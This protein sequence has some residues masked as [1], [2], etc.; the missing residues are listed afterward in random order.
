MGYITPCSPL[1]VNRRFGETSPR[2][3]LPPAFT[4]VS[5]SVYST[6]KVQ[7]ICSSEMSANFKLA[8]RRCIPEDSTPHNCRCE[9]LISNKIPE[10]GGWPLLPKRIVDRNIELHISTGTR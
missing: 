3:S 4:Q 8:I 5:S 2:S 9:N 10:E 1:K 6:L 7:A